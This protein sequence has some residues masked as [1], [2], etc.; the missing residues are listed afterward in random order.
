M[1]QIQEVRQ[2]L[3][4]EASGCRV[5]KRKIRRFVARRITPRRDEIR[6]FIAWSWLIPVALIM[7]QAIVDSI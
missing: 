5:M 6:E 1:G 3:V 2:G 7:A 4:E